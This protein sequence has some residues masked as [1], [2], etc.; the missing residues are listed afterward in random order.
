MA[1]LS[2]FESRKGDLTCTPS[3]LFDF[4]TDIRNFKQFIPAG[5]SI[6]DL[7]IE[8]ESCSFNISSMG[9]VTLNLFE[10]K[11]FDKVVYNG[12]LFQSNSYSLVVDIRENL[13]GKAEVHLKLAAQLNPLMKMLAAKP[14]ENFLGKM[15]EE[16]ER[17]RGWNT[18][19]R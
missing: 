18:P 4:A 2:V 10:K 11:P 1:D 17:F 13:T 8:S 3:E 12:T 6:N 7:N 15:I 14:I 19:K 5:A 9:N 16:M